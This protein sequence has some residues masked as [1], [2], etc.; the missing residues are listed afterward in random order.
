MRPPT[1]C[2]CLIK[3]SLSRL[4]DYVPPPHHPRSKPH[5]HPLMSDCVWCALR[6]ENPSAT[7]IRVYV[8]L[9][10]RQHRKKA[11]RLSPSLRSSQGINIFR[12]TSYLYCSPEKKANLSRHAVGT[13]YRSP[14]PPET[15]A[16]R[17][18]R[19]MGPTDCPLLFPPHD[20][21]RRRWRR[22]RGG[23]RCDAGAVHK[24]KITQFTSRAATKT[25]GPCPSLAVV[26]PFF[27]PAPRRR[28]GRGK[29]RGVS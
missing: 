27:L 11:R 3:S 16:A 4:T 8:V 23:D 12:G 14:R 5:I 6:R 29:G 15:D 13:I 25:D 21:L 17:M 19:S 28:E 26:P 2:V 18:Q 1:E 22:G 10:L 20:D 9:S 7:G 24:A